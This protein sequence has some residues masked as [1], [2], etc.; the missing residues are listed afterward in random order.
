MFGY[1]GITKEQVD[2]LK[3]KYSIY[4][5]SDG[6]MSICGLNTHNIDYVADAFHAITK[7]KKF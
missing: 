5:T 3:T 2:E 1:T 4:M 7:D 6:R